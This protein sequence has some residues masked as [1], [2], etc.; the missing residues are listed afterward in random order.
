MSKIFIYR[1]FAKKGSILVLTLWVLCFLAFF[2]LYLSQGVRQKLALVKRISFGSNLYYIADSGVKKAISILLQDETPYDLLKDDWSNNPTVFEKIKVGLGSFTVSYDYSEGANGTK[3]RFGCI[4][5]E[6]KLNVNTARRHTIQKL[7]EIVS[8]TDTIE[9]QAIAAAIVDWRDSD[10]MLSVPLR[11]A[12]DSYYDDLKEKYNCKDASFEVADELLLVKGMNRKLFDKI[13]DYITV[14]GSGKV[15]INTASEEVLM[16]FGID[17]R[18]AEKIIE[19]RKGEDTIEATSDDNLFS[20]PDQVVG[21]LSQFASFSDRQVAEL[22]NAISL[23]VF[24]TVSDTFLI[25]SIA[26][27]G[28]VEKEINCVVER[29]GKILYWRE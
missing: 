12:E 21:A 8:N 25:R 26:R 7:I 28:S 9:A 19:Y 13:K 11:S 2:G 18:M 15:N 14:Y 6:R 4:D 1:G 16:V 3:E 5:E 29:S 27:A 17:E 10:S 20:S 24:D 22:N 23:G